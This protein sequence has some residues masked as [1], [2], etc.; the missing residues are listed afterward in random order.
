MPNGVGEVLLFF[1]REFQFP[2][3]FGNSSINHFLSYP[4]HRALHDVTAIIDMAFLNLTNQRIPACFAPHELAEEEIMFF[5]PSRESSFKN[6]LDIL[7]DDLR[8][9]RLVVARE[10]LT[11]F[12]DPTV[13]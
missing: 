9:Q 1:Q 7:E 10:K 11:G 5:G 2:E 3:I 4:G 6:V 13:V 12:L 8:Y